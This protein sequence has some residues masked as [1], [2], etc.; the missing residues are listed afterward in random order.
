MPTEG[1]DPLVRGHTLGCAGY[2]RE[3]EVQ[4]MLRCVDGAIDGTHG[5]TIA[6]TQMILTGLDT[7]TATAEDACTEPVLIA[8]MCTS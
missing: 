7:L 2:G 1:D 3:A 8:P 4:G 5:D 6:L